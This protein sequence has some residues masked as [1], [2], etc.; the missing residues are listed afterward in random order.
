MTSYVIYS[1][2]KN[3]EKEEIDTSDSRREAEYLTSEYRMAFG[4]TFTMWYEEVN[5][6]SDEV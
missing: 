6:T 1:A 4:S 5:Y 2:Y 3:L